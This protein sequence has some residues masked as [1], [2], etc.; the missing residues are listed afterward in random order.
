MVFPV[1]FIL[2]VSGCTQTG[3][4]AENTDGMYPTGNTENKTQKQITVP[5]KNS[6]CPDSVTACPGG[7]EA[8]CSNVCV[9][10]T[11]T[12]CMPD[13]SEHYE[14]TEEQLQE[15]SKKPETLIEEKQTEEPAKTEKPRE[16]EQTQ[17]KITR[18]EYDPEGND[19]ENLNDEWI[20][21]SGYGTEITG[22][23]VSD[24][25]NHVYTFPE[26]IIYGKVKIHTGS[27]KDSSTEL[28]W[29][30]KTPVWN[31]DGDTATLKNRNGDTISI[32]EY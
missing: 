8:R 7:Y 20:E 15:L 19:R 11:C 29:N 22:W 18:I 16:P 21:I 5:C 14:P 23:T 2:F 28:Y 27:G 26:F 32:Y 10:E 25:A 13:C 24:A 6:I 12:F 30:M 4:I 9:N 1:I 3:R 17:P 31:N